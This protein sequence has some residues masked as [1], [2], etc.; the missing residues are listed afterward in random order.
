MTTTI[1]FRKLACG[2]IMTYAAVLLC[3]TIAVCP[4]CSYEVTDGGNFCTHCGAGL[5]TA[6]KPDKDTAPREPVVAGES[7]AADDNPRNALL[8][9]C[10]EQDRRTAAELMSQNSVAGSA[11]ALAAF[12][13]AKA[14]VALSEESAVPEEERKMIFSG[15]I[16][17]RT[18]I[19]KSPGVCPK[20]KGKGK[21]DEKREFSSLDGKTTVMKTGE[22]LC[23]RC[24]GNGGVVRL[25]NAGE[26]RSVIAEGRR[27]FADIALLAGRT[28]V[29]NA[30]LPKELATGLS[31]QEEA[32]LRHFTAE[33]CQACSGYGKN[34]CEACDGTGLVEC[35]EADCEDGLV[36]PPKPIGGNNAGEKITTLSNTLPKPCTRCNGQ[37]Y[38]A[39]GDCAGSGAVSCEVCKGSGERKACT[40]CLG[41]GTAP[42]RACKGAGKDKKGNECRVCKGEGIVLC[43]TCGG[44][45]YGRQ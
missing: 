8:S 29:G 45:G 2:V 11:A 32:T 23:R 17:A 12:I 3:A 6:V 43:P 21:E 41:E 22:R 18:A 1:S 9:K 24:N 28:K 34:G 13:N 27:K 44:D 25:R 20:C 31:S 38:A 26:M 30:W 7:K 36:K 10:I 19:T 33:P 15:M 14:V 37:G 42:C 40:K 4:E 39:C 5:K 35:P 16:N